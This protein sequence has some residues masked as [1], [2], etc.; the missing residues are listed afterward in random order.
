MRSYFRRII[1][2]KISLYLACNARSTNQL[3]EMGNCGGLY[4]YLLEKIIV[5]RYMK[6]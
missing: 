1:H 3:N 4:M 5:K 6:Y 2:L